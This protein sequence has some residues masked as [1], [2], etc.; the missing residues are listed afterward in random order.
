MPLIKQVITANKLLEVVPYLAGHIFLILT[1]SDTYHISILLLLLT[2][3]AE[4]H[5]CHL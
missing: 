1:K 3:L 5:I 4:R 2:L